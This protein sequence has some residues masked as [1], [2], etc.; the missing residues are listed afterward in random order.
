[1]SI[2]DKIDFDADFDAVV[3]KNTNDKNE[4]WVIAESI[5]AVVIRRNKNIMGPV[6][7]HEGFWVPRVIL[8]Q[9]V[10]AINQEKDLAHPNLDKVSASVRGQ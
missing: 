7:E 8:D 5:A 1:M 10:E 9:I 2:N 3:R 6:P 4:Y